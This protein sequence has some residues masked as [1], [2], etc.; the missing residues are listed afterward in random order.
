MI[1]SEIL[2]KAEKKDGRCAYLAGEYFYKEGNDFL[3]F[4]YVKIAADKKFLPAIVLLANFCRFGVGCKADL[5][6]ARKLYLFAAKRN[7]PTAMALFAETETRKDIFAVKRSIGLFRRAAKR[8]SAEGAYNLGL[9][10]LKGE[11]VKQMTERARYYL[12]LAAL[13]NYAPAIYELKDRAFN[14]FEA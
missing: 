5:K 6:K 10:Y 2:L 3:A 1:D 14:T 9:K 7:D 4:Y 12:T 13:K 8:G 11:G